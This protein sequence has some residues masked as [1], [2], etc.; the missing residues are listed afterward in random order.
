MAE[1]I[2]RESPPESAALA[3]AGEPLLTTIL[4]VQTQMYAQTHLLFSPKKACY[5][6]HGGTVVCHCCMALLRT[7]LRNAIPACS[8]DLMPL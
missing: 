3:C 1:P 6:N 8:I 2:Y 7:L 4:F 5:V